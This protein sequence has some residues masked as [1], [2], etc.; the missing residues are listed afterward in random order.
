MGVQERSFRSLK[1]H[2]A[3]LRKRKQMQ[4]YK[5][6]A[7]RLTPKPIVDFYYARIKKSL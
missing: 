7:L 6:K 3:N 2:V 5:L 1:Y 4:F